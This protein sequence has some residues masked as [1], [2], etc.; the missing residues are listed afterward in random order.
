[1]SLSVFRLLGLALAVTQ[2]QLATPAAPALRIGAQPRSWL[3]SGRVR[4][5]SIAKSSVLTIRG[6]ASRVPHIDEEEPDDDDAIDAELNGTPFGIGGLALPPVVTDTWQGTPP[7][8]RTFLT[9]SLLL[10]L[11]SS[12]F[13]QNNFPQLLEMSVPDVL[14]KLQVL[15][16][17]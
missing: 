6:G 5:Y 11:M 3:Q 12:I 14:Q 10:T 2:V 17:C 7:V 16:R 8:T 4:P 13:N 15:C 9:S 1:M